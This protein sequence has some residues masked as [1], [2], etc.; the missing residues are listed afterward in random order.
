MTQDEILDMKVYIVHLVEMQMEKYIGMPVSEVMADVIR[1]HLR[2]MM[3]NL[4]R[5]GHNPVTRLIDWDVVISGSNAQVLMRPKEG[6]S[7][8]DYKKVFDFISNREFA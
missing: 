3:E 7:D 4:F 1:I 5:Q 6:L 8:E 2:D